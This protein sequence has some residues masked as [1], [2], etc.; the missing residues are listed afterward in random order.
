MNGTGFKM[1]YEGYEA[2]Y[3]AI[4]DAKKVLSNVEFHSRDY[5]VNPDVMAWLKAKAKRTEQFQAL[6]KVEKEMLDILIDLQHQQ[7]EMNKRKTN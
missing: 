4:G 3:R 5:Y 6:E 7:E 1:L 2:A